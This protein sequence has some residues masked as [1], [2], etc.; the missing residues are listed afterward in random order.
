M[1]TKLRA[2]DELIAYKEEEI[3]RYKEM[4]A[5]L[6]TKMVGES[7]EQHCEIGVNKM[8]AAAFPR[9]TSKDNDVVDGTKGDFVFREADDEGGS[10]PV[11]SR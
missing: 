2:K 6:S 9:R 3:A 4:K 7:L 1:A 11:C 8:R 10:S 5:R